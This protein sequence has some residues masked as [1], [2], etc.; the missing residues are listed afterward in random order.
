M[1]ASYRGQKYIAE[2]VQSILKQKDM[3]VRLLISDDGGARQC[4]EFLK[5]KIVLV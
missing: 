1:L 2:Q 5:G 3:D 4:V